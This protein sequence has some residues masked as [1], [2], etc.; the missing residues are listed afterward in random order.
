ML[1][2]AAGSGAA[3]VVYV[4]ASSAISS[5]GS[6]ITLRL[7]TLT[8]G[9]GSAPQTGDLVVV[10]ATAASANTTTP[11]SNRTLSTG[12]TRLYQ[13]F[14]NDAYDTNLMI[15]YKIMGATPDTSCQLENPGAGNGTTM[16]AQVFRN[17][18]PEAPLGIG[19]VTTSQNTVLPFASALTRGLTVNK[20]G[21]LISAVGGGAHIGGVQTYTSSNLTS[22]RTSGAN[23]TNDATIG[24][25]LATGAP[26]TF[27]PAQF[28]FSTSNSTTY[29]CSGVITA[30][31]PTESVVIPTLV[32]SNSAAIASGTTITITRASLS[33]QNGDLIVAYAACDDSTVTLTP[34][35]GFTTL[36]TSTSGDMLNALLVK[37]ANNESSDYAFTYSNTLNNK[38][39]IMFVIRNWTSYSLK[40]FAAAT[41][42]SASTFIVTPKIIESPADMNKTG[43]SFVFSQSD[44]IDGG[45]FGTPANFFGYGNGTFATRLVSGIAG[46]ARFVQPPSS[47]SFLLAAAN[48]GSDAALVY[49]AL[50]VTS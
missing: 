21:M 32:S 45:G 37:T 40:S 42:Y 35:S 49:A 50:H 30:I 7:D 6:S 2:A 1:R 22:F 36:S 46:T 13:S 41:S 43:L 15:Y 27:T 24:A 31:N 5:G 38:A 28:G 12:F 34:P 29:S 20:T 18:D 4:G 14:E 39:V 9:V 47:Y 16:I 8:G 17:V 44:Q 33:P 25:G 19:S 10:Y 11:I 3:G 48:E 26:T 23:S